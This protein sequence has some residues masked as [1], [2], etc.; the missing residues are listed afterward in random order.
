[1]ASWDVGDV[2][3]FLSLVGPLSLSERA[4]EGLCGVHYAGRFVQWG[5][6]RAYRPVGLWGSDVIVIKEEA[7]LCP[8]PLAFYSLSKSST[9]GYSPSQEKAMF[10]GP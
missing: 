5:A 6:L 3:A 2:A 8:G 9:P 7:L 10:Y 1:M 4:I